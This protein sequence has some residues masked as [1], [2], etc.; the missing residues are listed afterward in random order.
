V[1]HIFP[2]TT[3]FRLWFRR[4]GKKRSVVI[5]LSLARRARD[6]IAEAL[7]HHARLGFRRSLFERDELQFAHAALKL[8]GANG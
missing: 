3:L 1:H 5:V 8:S 4:L 6:A 2:Y 7:R